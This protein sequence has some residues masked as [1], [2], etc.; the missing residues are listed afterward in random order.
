MQSAENVQVCTKNNSDS[1]KFD[2]ICLDDKQEKVIENGIYKIELKENSNIVLQ[3]ENASEKNG[4]NINTG[5]WLSDSSNVQKR[6]K[7]TYNEDDGYYT[8]K[9]LNS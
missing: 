6:F 3:T 1:Q 9:S 4:G 7:I 5:K 2:L 8:I